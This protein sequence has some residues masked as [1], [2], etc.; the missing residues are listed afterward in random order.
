MAVPLYSYQF[1]AAL[2]LNGSLPYTVPGDV[3]AVLR[4]LDAYYNGLVEASIH[5]EGSLGQTIWYNGFS[6]GGNPQY[7]SWRGRQ[8]LDPGDTLTVTTDQAIDVTISG[9]LLSLP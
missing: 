7:A 9:Y 2:G 6:A 5:L 1:L 3:R 4:D 8:V